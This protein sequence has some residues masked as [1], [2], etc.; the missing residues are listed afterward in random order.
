MIDFTNCP[1]NRFRAYGG[2]NGNKIN[3]TYQGHSYMLKFPPKPSRNR[4]MSYSNGCISEYV[5]CHIFEM[6]GFR[7][8]ETLLGN[9][10]DSRGKTKLVV[11]CRDFTEDGKRLIE[12]AHLKNTCIDSEQ[13]G[14]GKELSSILEAIEEQSIYPSD[15]LRQF[16]WDMFIA[17]AFLGNFDRHNGNW[18][19][20]Y[21]AQTDQMT[22]A[23][24][25]DCGSSLYPQADEKIM[26]TVLASEQD[27]NYRIFEIPTSA[28]MVNG[29]KIKYFDFISSLQNEDCNRALKRIVPRIDMA[30]IRKLIADTPFITDLQKRFYC[31]MLEK[32]KERILDY[33]L[34]R[35]KNAPTKRHPVKQDRGAR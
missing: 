34:E 25:Y 33:S 31:T 28:I 13:N 23:P 14:Y 18:G 12:F 21:D 7:T 9:Y 15:E 8:Q 10:T 3:I 2:A 1:V 24:V 6:L 4:D 29:K 17:D 16:F 35:L 11:A 27:M 20:L 5:A 32:R 30:R 26:E 22:L 19:F